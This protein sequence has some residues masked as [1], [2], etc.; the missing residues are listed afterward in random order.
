M[1]IKQDKYTVG[2][3]VR[4]VDLETLKKIE[5]DITKSKGIWARKVMT[6]KEQIKGT[7]DYRMVEDAANGYIG[8]WF[9]DMIQGKVVEDM[10]TITHDGK[11]Y[12]KVQRRARVGEL[13]LIVDGDGHGNPV[14]TVGK[15]KYVYEITPTT[16]WIDIEFGDGCIRLEQYV[17]LAPVTMSNE[18]HPPVCPSCGQILPVKRTYTAEQIEEA[19]EI[20]YRLMTA[21]NNEAI[22][23]FRH[24]Q[25]TGVRKLVNKGDKVWFEKS[26]NKAE[27]SDTD[28]CQDDIGRMV[29]LSKLTGT[30]LPEW[31]D[32]G[33]R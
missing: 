8:Y 19:R 9:S 26:T 24:G 10:D 22:C 12:R 17:V 3:V 21:E 14:G 16:G 5:G 25:K 28:E 18:P 30:P 6:I 31:L 7:K 32:S 33:A 13:V 2:D 4:I 1:I 15:V 23:F 29:A 20:V 11:Q 27:C